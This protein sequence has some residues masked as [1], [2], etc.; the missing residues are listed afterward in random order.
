MEEKKIV[1][2][3]PVSVV[4]L[5]LIPVTQVSLGLWSARAGE[6]F[7][8]IKQPLAVVVVS[9]QAKRAFRITGE[10]VLLEEL[11]QEYPGLKDYL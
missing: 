4:G 5:N 2:N 11:V 7:L 6:A 10:E 8:A 9:P 3:K 1:I